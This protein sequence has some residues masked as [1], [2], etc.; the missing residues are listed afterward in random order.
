MRNLNQA[1]ALVTTSPVTATDQ[2][3]L[4]MPVDV[5]LSFIAILAVM[6]YVLPSSPQE[7]VYFVDERVRWR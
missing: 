2:T 7:K 1:F 3:T 6:M 4:K 5:S